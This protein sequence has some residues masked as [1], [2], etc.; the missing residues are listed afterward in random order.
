MGPSPSLSPPRPIARLPSRIVYR[1]I[2]SP[3]F[4][5]VFSDLVGKVGRFPLFLGGSSLSRAACRAYVQCISYGME[6]DAKGMCKKKPLILNRLFFTFLACPR[7]VTQRRAPGEN[8]LPA[9]SVVLGTFRKLALRAQT[10]EMLCPQTRS[11][12]WNFRMG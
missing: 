2:Q 11:R 5:W 9:C 10:S 1:Y 7:K 4:D 12:A 3:F 8:S 6:G